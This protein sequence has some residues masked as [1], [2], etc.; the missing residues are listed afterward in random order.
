MRDLISELNKRREEGRLVVDEELF[1]VDNSPLSKVELN[2]AEGKLGFKLTPTLRRIFTEVA[3]GGFGPQYGLL[4]LRGGMRNE[5]GC[6]AVDQYLAYQEPDPEDIHWEWPNE[7][8]PLG[9]LG[10]GMYLCVD[11]SHNEGPITL[12]EP[13]PHEAGEAWN[14]SFFP[15]ADSTEIWLLGWLDGEDLFLKLSHGE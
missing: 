3:N 13:N 15:F 6:D 11:C 2:S 5:D 9:H 4:G 8:L 10:C 12:F 14:D 1:E 7:L